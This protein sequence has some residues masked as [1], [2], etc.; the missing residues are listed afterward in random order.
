MVLDFSAL[1]STCGCVNEPPASFEDA[2]A[3]IWDMAEMIH[4]NLAVPWPKAA[5]SRNRLLDMRIAE[6]EALIRLMRLAQTLP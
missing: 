3:Q 5:S 1:P 4:E 6:C 2:L